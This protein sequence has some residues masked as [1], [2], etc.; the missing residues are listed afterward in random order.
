MGRGL[1]N[2]FTFKDWGYIAHIQ[3]NIGK[4]KFKIETLRMYNKKLLL[5]TRDELR[6]LIR[7]MFWKYSL[8]EMLW[9]EKDAKLF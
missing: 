2:P 9:I 3:N 4:D 1:K 6:R 7:K 5:L 8:E